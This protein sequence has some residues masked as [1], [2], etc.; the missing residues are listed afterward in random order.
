MNRVVHFTI[1]TIMGTL[2]LLLTSLAFASEI[3]YA[4]DT[5]E[6]IERREKWIEGAKKE[7]N[8]VLW[9]TLNPSIAAKLIADFNQLYPFI[10]VDY[11]RG[12]GEEVAAKLE[13]GYIANRHD[14][15][16]IHTG[17]AP[18]YPRWRKLGWIEKFSHIIPD[19]KRIEKR[20]Y[21]KY[22]DTFNPGNNAMTPQYN[23]KLVS[24]SEA[25]RRWEDLIDPKWKGQ[26]IGMTTDMK[27]WCTLAIAGGWGVEKTDNFLS[28]LK[29]QKPLWVKGH[30][31]G[32]TLMIAG[33]FKVMASDYLYHIFNSKQKGA[34]VEW[35]RAQPVPVAGGNTLLAKNAPHPNAAWLFM[36]WHTSDPGLKSYTRVTG[37][38]GPIFPGFDNPSAK[39]VDGLVLAPL[40]EEHEEKIAAMDL[41]NKFAKT[42]NITPTED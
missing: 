38:R 1:I 34:P 29:E 7:G 40:T 36:E 23:T 35:V 17:D 4:G 21:S 6:A 31:E 42:L 20:M 13:A 18:R 19:I 8:L 22:G 28:K 14:V 27:V 37:G 32:H 11:W 12:K 39:A 25:P 3:R 26:Q 41:R 16:V 24:S 9:M 10:K 30:S 5:K 2:I 15:D 33:E